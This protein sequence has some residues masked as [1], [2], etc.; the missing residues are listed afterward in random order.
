[1]NVIVDDRDKNIMMRQL[2][3]EKTSESPLPP[4]DIKKDLIISAG[5]GL[6]E[7]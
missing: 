7:G 6:G 4:Y 3:F 1:V 5:E 2:Y